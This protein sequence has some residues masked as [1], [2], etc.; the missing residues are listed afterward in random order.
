MTKFQDKQEKEKKKQEQEE[1]KKNEQ[2]TTN[3][4][5]AQVKE[6]T[7][8]E[9]EKAKLE[10]ELKNKINNNPELKEKID[11]INKENT[12][13]TE[14]KE[15]DKVAEGK[16]RPNKG[17]GASLEKYF[18]YQYTIQEITIIIP[19]EKKI[20]GKDIK[21]K[22]DSKHLNVTVA[23]ENILNGELKHPMNVK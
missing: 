20:T 6:L 5:Q 14:E 21:I 19:V 8:E 1:R 3:K 7:K 9:F 4:P 17:N 13:K 16:I 18:W 23:G 10:E 12:T 22:Q 2:Q 15:E 11:Q